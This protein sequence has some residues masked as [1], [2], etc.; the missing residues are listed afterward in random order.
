MNV[1][2]VRRGSIAYLTGGLTS[3]FV[4]F[5][6]AFAICLWM[7]TDV[8]ST[9]ATLTDSPS[10]PG[11]PVV[12]VGLAAHGGTD[13]ETTL[14]GLATDLEAFVSAIGD[15]QA[16]GDPAARLEDV[17]V[18]FDLERDDEL[19]RLSA[20]IDDLTTAIQERERAFDERR[21]ELRAANERLGAIVEA[22]PT[23]LVAVDTDGTVERWN[24]AATEI[25]GWS[26]A[27]VLGD[28]PPF[29]PDDRIDEHERIRERL[30]DGESIADV[31][32]ERL[33]KDGERID[34]TLS[35]APMRDAEGEVIGAMG[36]LTD[37]TDRKE[38]ERERE[39]IRSR[40]EALFDNSP[41]MI[42][43]L[44]TEGTIVDANQRFREKL[45]YDEGEL[46]GTGIWEHDQL[47]DAD[48]VTSL[49]EEMSVG[50]RRKFEGRYRRRD[51][52]TFPVEIH[53]IRIDLE[54]GDECFVAISRDITDRT[55]RE[56]SLRER[57]RQFTTLVSNVP[58]MVYRC[59]NE[60]EWPFQFVSDGCVELTGYEPEQLVADVDWSSDVILDRHDE[61]WERVQEAVDER[62]PFQV[63]FPIETADGD[64]RWVT[65]RGRGVFDADGSLEALEGVITDVTERIE[66]R[67]ELERT[68]QLLEKSQ[69]LATVGAW[70]LDV[71]EEPYDLHWT[72]EVARIYGLS[73]DDDVGLDAALEHYHPDDRATL[74]AAVDR[75]IETGTAYDL[76]LRLETAD[77]DRRWVRSIG[78]PIREDG[79]VVKL[80]G[81]VQDVTAQKRRERDL[82]ETKRRLELTLEGTNT[83]IW[84]LNLETNELD[85]SE[86]LQ[87]LVGL[88]PG[89]FEGT[90][91]AFRSRVHPNDIIRVESAFER[92]IENDELYQDEFRIRH[93]DGDW[94]WV[95]A[96]A[97]LVTDD[98][99]T[100]RMV[101]INYD[102]TD[103]KRRERELERYETI[104]QAV[105]DPVYTLDPSG[106]IRFV[107]DAIESLVGYD[108]ETLIGSDVSKILPQRDLERARNVV[109]KLLGRDEPY[110]TLETDFRTVDGDTVETE[111]HIALLPAEEG[112]FAGT[113]GVV[114]DITDRKERE[115]ELERTTE[116]LE[117][118]QRLAG[119]G[120]WELD[121]STD[122]Y[123]LTVTEQ[124]QRLFDRDDPSEQERDLSDVIASY[125]PEDRPRVL[126]A[127]EDAVER[128]ESYDLEVRMYTADGDERWMRTI[129][130]PIREDGE[131]V[132]IRGSV[133]DITDRKERERDLERTRDL[134][135]QVQR[136]AGVGGWELDTEDDPPTAIWTDELYRLHDLPR[137]VD[138]D[139]ERTLECYHPEDRGY[140]REQLESAMAAERA[141]ELEGRL[142]SDDGDITWVQAHGHP[143]FDEDGDLVAYRGSV[144]DISD[145]KRRE[146]A[147]ESLHETARG[148]LNAET[149]STIADLVTE[150]AA[151]LLEADAA[152][153][154]V[155]L[156][157]AETNRFEPVASTAGFLDR[158]GDPP[159]VA[160]GDGDSVLWTTYVTGTQTVVDDP[161]LGTRSPLFGGDAPGGLLV[162]IGDHG[163]FVLVAPPERI[164]DETRQLFETLVATTEAAFDRLESETTLRERDA[165]LEAQNRRL[166]RQ[167]QI[168]EI[169]RGI[170]RSLIGAESREGIERTVPE[171]LVEADDIAFAWIGDL[172]ASGTTVE[173]RT[174]AGSRPEYLD[175]SS[176]D[177]EGDAVEPAARTAR[178]ETP[179]VVE[180]V[181]EE[182]QAESWRTD[183][184][185][186]GFQSVVAVPLR[187]EEYSY[188]VLAVYAD[189]PAV[190]TDLERSVFTELGEGI[191]NAINA[192]ETREALHAETVV[193]LTL[194]LE[195]GELLSRLASATGATVTY[196]G[197]GTHSG[198]K[199][200]LF[201]ETS[202]VPSEVLRDVLV[203]LV[204]VTDVRLVTESDDDCL[205][206]ATVT[207]DTVASRLVRH[208]GSPRSIVADGERTEIT[209]DV[210]TTTDVREFVEMLEEEYA[211]VDLQSRRHVQRALRTRRELVTSLFEEL[212]DRQR[213]V[214]RTAYLAGFFEW[215]R[216]STGEEIAEMLE[217]T[218]PTVN[219]HLRVGQQRLLDELFRAESV[220]IGD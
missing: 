219:R 199:S 78:E 26:D 105:G 42:D 147:L 190:F 47:F 201:F 198:S 19:G 144:Q 98:D 95:G 203:D 209:V 54:E 107:N 214:L 181:V 29:V 2:S 11:L 151:E 81:S 114:R 120:G 210:P 101:G 80:R 207:G 146:L 5:A 206:E 164:G 130:E 91:D 31:E 213:E 142:Q 86:T 109:Q 148:L 66:N 72:D 168:T 160:V 102:I 106:E 186:A 6:M 12:L 58:G 76:E 202:G 64:R 154:G 126:S 197:L 45:G 48:E 51:G 104:V 220:S 75:A 63:T 99:G 71:R 167:I 133:Q 70:E 21:R 35:A 24:P 37:I 196:E 192:A 25:F 52:S 79:T 15:G 68:T 17:D 50:D 189:E 9:V 143:I 208:G 140:V 177:L 180:N 46:V 165:E 20:A 82:R 170:D 83:G 49:L 179:T 152:S 125:H 195:G 1:L 150:T 157:D 187:F 119:I 156:L 135:E 39:R 115:R 174:W 33:R 62:E 10:V 74:R 128:G 149:E 110:D 218:Q 22:S 14:E 211:D 108:P 163:V 67:Q 57:E 184:L 121:V 16:D 40:L 55:E 158:S 200:V 92:A 60:P 69:R 94:I 73:S 127:V 138:P 161:E 118:A 90:Y 204:S 171:R 7:W 178:S 89:T 166:R 4:L 183:A 185:D 205:F 13:R 113:A 159:S 217:V 129:G 44:D 32:T 18:T 175:A 137:D 87:R 65:E 136:I 116:L 123:E 27:E 155:Y 84:E 38:R 215:P 124:L 56:R 93:E 53:L 176:F 41:D 182:F 77:G 96:R 216:E 172:D 173:P 100:R 134:L 61:L 85:W 88:D 34:V 139:L 193:E 122:P 169:I 8:A 188:G 132:T 59:R 97:R 28:F 162:P 112:G 23:A 103:R 194:D 3:P 191:A 111:T 117:Q 212:T 30:L 43:V 141:Y 131:V 145:R 153:A 36:V